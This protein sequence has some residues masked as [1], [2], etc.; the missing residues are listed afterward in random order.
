[1]TPVLQLNFQDLNYL[2]SNCWKLSLVPWSQSPKP[3]GT[4]ACTIFCIWY[5]YKKLTLVNRSVTR[6]RWTSRSHQR[7][8][9][10]TGR[11]ICKNGSA[12]FIVSNCFGH[13]QVTYSFFVVGCCPRLMTILILCASS[14][15]MKLYCIIIMW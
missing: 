1:M 2:L 7:K 9:V 15:N 10:M 14:K 8:Y 3:Q 12:G 11:K 5:N 13:F 6:V 4:G